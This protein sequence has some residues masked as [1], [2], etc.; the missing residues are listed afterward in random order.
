MHCIYIE[1]SLCAFSCGFYI[2]RKGGT[3]GGEW[4]H[5][6]GAMR[7]AA[8]RLG[9]RAMVG[10]S[11]ANSHICCMNRLRKCYPH[12]LGGSFLV[13]KASLALS[14]CLPNEDADYCMLMSGCG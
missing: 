7:M 10:T 14:G 4:S 13:G 2:S 11:W 3:G 1:D 6:Q 5:L 12:H 8:A 9:L